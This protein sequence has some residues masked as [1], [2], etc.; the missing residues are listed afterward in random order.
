MNRL[1]KI[2]T[3]IIPKFYILYV[4][5]LAHLEKFGYDEKTRTSLG[6]FGWRAVYASRHEKSDALWKQR[7]LFDV[8]AVVTSNS[9]GYIWQI[10]LHMAFKQLCVTL[11][12]LM[13]F[14]RIIAHDYTYMFTYNIINHNWSSQTHIASIRSA[15]LIYVSRR[16]PLWVDYFSVF[17]HC[18]TTPYTFEFSLNG[19][20][21]CR[22]Y[23]ITRKQK[24]SSS[25]MLLPVGIEPMASNFNDLHA[26]VW[27]N[28]LFA[29]S[30]T[31]IRFLYS[32]ALFQR[33]SRAWHSVQFP[34][35]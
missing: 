28:S 19:D 2:W 34:M 4:S 32:H 24:K 27:A 3:V 16:Y 31:T 22:V 9:L 6:Q 5:D 33:I 29:G 30:F 10:I 35:G 20:A 15:L 8:T 14:P 21:F 23:R 25:K 17:Q 1:W 18:Y 12:T 13:S 11:P 26:T 7:N